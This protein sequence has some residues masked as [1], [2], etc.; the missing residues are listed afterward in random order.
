MRPRL[1][2]C[3]LLFLKV[4]RQCP[5]WL[6][7]N[8]RNVQATPA[9]D[10][11]GYNVIISLSAVDAKGLPLQGLT[12]SNF[13]IKEDGKDVTN[14]KV[15]PYAPPINVVLAIDTSETMTYQIEGMKEA[16]ITF[17]KGLSQ[18]DQ[19]GLVS[20][21]SKQ[22]TEHSLT[23]GN[24]DVVNAVLRLK[25]VPNTVMC[26]WDAAY[27]AAQ[28]ASSSP[29]GQRAIVMLTSGLDYAQ[30]GRTC[31][32]KTIDD[33]INL[34][35][36]NTSRVPIHIVAM[37]Q[38]ARTQEVSR[39]AELT[40]GQV[41]FV[42]SGKEASTYLTALSQQMRSGYQI[43]YTSSISSGEHS[44]FLQLD[45]QGSRAQTTQKFNTQTLGSL[46]VDG[47]ENGQTVSANLQVSVGSGGQTQIAR[48]VLLVND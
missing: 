2:F 22:T 24:A 17:L 41:F 30:P 47:V 37:K 38:W 3:S 11:S 23:T 34:A 45:H 4:Q 20:F 31:S 44:L 25:A 39:L 42:E 26:L 9:I 19:S 7:A 27:Y 5:E 12:N 48:V 14:F 35:T 15:A 13:T 43:G 6:A 8:V 32:N 33:V 16:G 28:L 18:G 36:D 40:G 10:K 1:L 46:A 29:T 21:N